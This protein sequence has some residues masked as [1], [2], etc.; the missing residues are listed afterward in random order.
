MAHVPPNYLAKVLQQLSGAGLISGRRGVGGGYRLSRA[1]AKI[2]LL[3]I[4]NAIG[5]VRKIDSCPCDAG[6]NGR[7]P[8]C[9]LHARTAAVVSAAID[10]YS[11]TTLNDLLTDNKPNKPVCSVHSPRCEPADDAQR[12]P[13]SR[14]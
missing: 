9:P 1:P 5:E 13:A 3:D 12:P 7:A 10:I 6:Q 8:L 2:T 14:H 4:V 11:G